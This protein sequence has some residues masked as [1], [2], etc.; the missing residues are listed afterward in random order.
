[1]LLFFYIEYHYFIIIDIYYVTGSSTSSGLKSYGKLLGRLSSQDW[2][3]IVE[4]N[5]KAYSK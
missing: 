1:M 4:K 5:M 3:A 2:T